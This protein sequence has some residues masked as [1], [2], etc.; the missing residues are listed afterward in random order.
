MD[1]L[2]S[3]ISWLFLPLFTPIYGLLV[4]LYLPIPSSSFLSSN[5]LFLLNPTAKFLFISLF[6]VFIVLAPGVSFLVMKMNRNIHSFEMRTIEE[7]LAPISLT[8]FYLIVLLFF[9]YFQSEDALIPPIIKA[10]VLGGII[11]GALAYI[12]TPRLK[13]SLHSIG[14]GALFG[15]IYMF[16]KGLEYSPLILLASIIILGGIVLTARLVLKAHTMKEVGLGYL[17]GFLS[18]AICIWLYV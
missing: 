15:F 12:I 13:I 14:M 9:L 8:T 17:L 16:S 18:Q 6:V 5:S 7:R 11:A 10:M 4:I 3:F 2:A 1:K